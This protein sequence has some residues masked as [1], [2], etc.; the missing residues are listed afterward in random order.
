ML[1]RLP[2]SYPL[3]SSEEKLKC[4]KIPAALELHICNRHNKPE[5][6]YL[7]CRSHF[8][9]II[10]LKGR[11]AQSTNIFRKSSMIPRYLIL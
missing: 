2:Q 1:K 9:F 3:M 7:I 11:R 4:C 6:Y 8:F 10:I 5:D